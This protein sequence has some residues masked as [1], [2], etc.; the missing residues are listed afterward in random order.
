MRCVKPGPPVGVLEAVVSLLQ[1][2]LQI[3]RPLSES[4]EFCFEQPQGR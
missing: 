2:S 3:S 1:R 4:V